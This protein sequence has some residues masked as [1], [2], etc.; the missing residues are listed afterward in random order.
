MSEILAAASANSKPP[1][2]DEDK[3]HPL[4]L[5]SVDKF[6]LCLWRN[7]AVDVFE[8]H[9]WDSMILQMIWNSHITCYKYVHSISLL[10]E[11]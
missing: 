7:D 1:G 11:E 5:D 2:S 9:A 8:M 3:L 10:A 4:T 6:P